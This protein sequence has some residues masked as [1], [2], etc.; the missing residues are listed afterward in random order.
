[1]IEKSQSYLKKREL[2]KREIEALGDE[3][4]SDCREIVAKVHSNDFS[5]AKKL[6]NGSRSRL[7]K[8]LNITKAPNRFCDWGYILQV[9]QEYLEASVLY[10]IIVGI[11]A[12]ILRLIEQFP[13]QSILY[14]F[15]DLVGELRRRVLT[16]LT[17]GNVEKAR[18]YASVMM[19]LYSKLERVSLPDSIVPGLRR[20]LDVNR[21]SL[22]LTFSDLSE[23]VSRKRLRDSIDSLRELV[24]RSE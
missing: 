2:K 14:G 18:L 16:E 9:L 15:S 5:S 13:E 22:D 8:F 20:K 21:S 11:D 23:E 24:G 19:E 7:R 4:L 6:L 3:L 17:K 12:G 1:M 10:M